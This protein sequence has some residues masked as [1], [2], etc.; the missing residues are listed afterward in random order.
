[1]TVITAFSSPLAPYVAG[2]GERKRASVSL[3][4]SPREVLAEVQ[5]V[6]GTSSLLLCVC[7]AAGQRAG[8]LALLPALQR[9]PL[10][11]H[12][13][14]QGKQRNAIICEIDDY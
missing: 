5:W 10:T 11:E 14:V 6:V 12:W 8:T 3:G 13:P 9:K 1:M 4:L 7:P 2:Y